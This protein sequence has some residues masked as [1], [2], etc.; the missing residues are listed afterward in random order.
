MRDFFQ[1]IY[2]G[3]FFARLGH[4]HE[5]CTELHAAFLQNVDIV[6]AV[7]K[8]SRMGHSVKVSL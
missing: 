8:G 5:H 4:F 2:T 3:I 6:D 7:F 1:R